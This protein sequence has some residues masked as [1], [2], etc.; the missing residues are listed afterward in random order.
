VPT[1]N[2]IDRL[3]ETG[4]LPCR[5]QLPPGSTPARPNAPAALHIRGLT[6]IDNQPFAEASPPCDTIPHPTKL[7][8]RRH[9][10]SPPSNLSNHTLWRKGPYYAF[11]VS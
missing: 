7:W 5:G 4:A 11:V 2:D 3:S 6:V 8:F 9:S 1:P 10:M